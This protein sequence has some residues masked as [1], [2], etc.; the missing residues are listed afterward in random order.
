MHRR[1]ETECMARHD[2]GIDKNGNFNKWNTN[3][4]SKGVKSQHAGPRGSLGAGDLG[5]VRAH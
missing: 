3:E 2:E 1:T 5:R 4:W